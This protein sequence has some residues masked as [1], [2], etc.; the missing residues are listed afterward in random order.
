M[1]V[2]FIE[3]WFLDLVFSVRVIGNMFNMVDRFVMRMGWKCVLVVFLMV[4]RWFSLVF[5]C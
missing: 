4:F 1:I 5:F 2:I 3:I